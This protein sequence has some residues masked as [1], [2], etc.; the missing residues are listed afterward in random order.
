MA[1]NPDGT[2]IIYDVPSI[3]GGTINGGYQCPI[4]GGWFAVGGVHGCLGYTTASSNGRQCERCGQWVFG[5]VHHA[6]PSPAC[7]H[8]HCIDVPPSGERTRPHAKCCQC[9][10]VRLGKAIDG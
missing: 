1:M 7:Q 3:P 8:C 6:C 5:G 9:G 10:T 2:S 4:C